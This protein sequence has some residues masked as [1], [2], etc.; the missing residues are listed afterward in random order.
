MT[1]FLTNQLQESVRNQD[2]SV[3]VGK[4][5]WDQDAASIGC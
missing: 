4:A 2:R 5:C 1:D 3:S